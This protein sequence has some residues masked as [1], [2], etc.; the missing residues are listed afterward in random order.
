MDNKDLIK[1]HWDNQRNWVNKQ[2]NGKPE[3]E[4]KRDIELANLRVAGF[5]QLHSSNFIYTL[6][7]IIIA[8]AQEDKAR[9]DRQVF[10]II[11]KIIASHEIKANTLNLGTTQVMGL[12]TGLAWPSLED[13][14]PIV[15]TLQGAENY[16]DSRIDGIFAAYIELYRGKWRPVDYLYYQMTHALQN[17]RK[18]RYEDLLG[19]KQLDMLNCEK[20]AKEYYQET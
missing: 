8:A 4:R 3:E 11:A 15:Q 18:L 12:L 13:I 16:V 14:S 1:K 19:I 9:S 2:F 5:L 6:T 20:G 7:S 17:Q 10:K